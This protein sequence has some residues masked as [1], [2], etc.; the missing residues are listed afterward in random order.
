MKKMMV[1]CLLG[2]GLILSRHSFG[3]ER[4]LPPSVTNPLLAAE[5]IPEVMTP[6]VDHEALAREDAA[7]AAAPHLLILDTHL[8][9][10]M[11][12]SRTLFGDCPDWL[13]AE[14][15]ARE[16]H[17][18]LL[19]SPRGAEWHA[20]GQRC[21]P[22]V[23]D[24]QRFYEQCRDWLRQHRQPFVEVAGNWAERERQAIASTQ[25]LLDG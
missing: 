25:A 9:S 3:L 14:L 13:E 5:A 19:L 6:T 16:Y 22:D 7:R 8:L 18:H 10:N 4:L 17:Q 15:Q 20:D 1:L 2:F 12:W 24:R 23:D 11:L 21:Q